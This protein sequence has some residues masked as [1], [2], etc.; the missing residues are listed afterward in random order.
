[1]S[2]HE[3][4]DNAAQE[5]LN[6]FL[7]DWT[8]LVKQYPAHMDE[9][10]VA[11]SNQQVACES[12]AAQSLSQLLQAQ[13]PQLQ[14]ACATYM[15]LGEALSLGVTGDVADSVGQLRAELLPLFEDTAFLAKLDPQLQLVFRLAGSGALASLTTLI[16]VKAQQKNSDEPWFEGFIQRMQSVYGSNPLHVD[17]PS[18]QQALQAFESARLMHQQHF[19]QLLLQ[20][21]D[22]LVVSLPDSKLSADSGIRDI[23]NLWVQHA[24]SVHAERAMSA[25]Y[26]HIFGRWMNTAMQLRQQLEALLQQQAELFNLPSRVELDEIHRQQLELRRENRKLKRQLS[27]QGALIARVA[28]GLEPKAIPL[29]VNSK[30]QKR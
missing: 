1:M 2:S 14:N 3:S 21:F 7:A 24:E 19:S 10:A 30:R 28:A 25:E 13:W 20:S 27:R 26:Q 18:L 4:F 23:Y 11:S 29:T 17:W 15:T 6:R 9:D 5:S 16:S 12:G 22:D 8:T